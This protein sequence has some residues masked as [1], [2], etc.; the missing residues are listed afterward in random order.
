MPRQVGRCIEC[1]APH[2]AYA[3]RIICCVCKELVLVCPACDSGAALT[4]RQ[5]HCEAHRELRS[6]FFRFLEPFSQSQLE[7]HESVLVALL[8]P[9]S[10]ESASASATTDRATAATSSGSRSRRR[11]LRKQV[12]RVRER[13][14][15]L[16][17]GDVSP[18]ALAEWAA[19]PGCVSCGERQCDG[20]CWG[21]WA[22]AG[23]VAVRN[24]RTGKWTSRNHLL[25]VV[26]N[27]SAPGTATVVAATQERPRLAVGARVNRGPDWR[28]GRQ[29]GGVG[30]EGV[31]ESVGLSVA[32]SVGVF[33]DTGLIQVKWDRT[34]VSQP[35]RYGARGRYDVVAAVDRKPDSPPP[36]KLIKL[37][38]DQQ[39]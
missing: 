22:A 20:A 33:T 26:P 34:G 1:G 38:T 17:S 18:V 36:S 15:L 6:C 30:G 19:A 28:W 37:H 25:D 12:Q 39:Q 10:V 13:L 16:R 23:G 4:A 27:A 35:Y 7:V 29:D 32:S 14:K 21:V 8:E 24:N 2:D 11:T 5:Y 9:P 31:V 3:P